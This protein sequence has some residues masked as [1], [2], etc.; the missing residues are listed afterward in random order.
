MEPSSSNPKLQ[1]IAD[2]I[3]TSYRPVNM[4][5]NQ[6]QRS[7]ESAA[8]N[9]V[10]LSE[11]QELKDALRYTEFQLSKTRSEKELFESQIKSGADQMAHLQDQM[12]DMQNRFEAQKHTEEQEQRRKDLDTQAQESLNSQA[13]DKLNNFSR[14]ISIRETEMTTLQHKEKKTKETLA[15]ATVSEQL[16]RS[17]ALEL[18]DQ[19]QDKEF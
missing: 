4:Q 7:A 10:N 1:E 3:G 17:K 8:W 6:Q 9:K 19:A 16:M 12:K 14:E 2:T 15:S 5:I 11:I 18:V 13:R